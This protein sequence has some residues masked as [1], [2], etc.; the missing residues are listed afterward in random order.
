MPRRYRWPVL[1]SSRV[2][3]QSAPETASPAAGRPLRMAACPPSSASST[4]CRYLAA[5]LQQGRVGGQGQRSA[6]AAKRHVWLLGMPSYGLP[7]RLRKHISRAAT[8]PPPMQPPSAPGSRLGRIGSSGSGSPTGG[9]HGGCTVMPAGSWC[10]VL[11]A[12]AGHA[13]SLPHRA[14]SLERLLHHGQQGLQAGAARVPPLAP[15]AMP[16]LHA[17]A[18]QRWRCHPGAVIQGLG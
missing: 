10:A 12:L 2:G 6:G 8:H 13:S 16:V 4:C 1:V 11:R 14:L 15:C 17:A 3:R 7:V 5:A 18:V 9:G